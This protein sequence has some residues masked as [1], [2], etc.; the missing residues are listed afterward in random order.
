MKLMLSAFCATLI[1]APLSY[2]EGC[3]KGKCDK[4]KQE[5]TVADCGKCKKD[6][7]KKEEGALLAGKCEKDGDCDKEEEGTLADCGKC[8][9]DGDDEEEGTL[10]AGKCE[11]EPPPRREMGEHHVVYCQ[12]TEAELAEHQRLVD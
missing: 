9:K 10:I 11:S 5:E 4:E 7:E 3:E 6:D 8:K 12:H 1:V 2:G